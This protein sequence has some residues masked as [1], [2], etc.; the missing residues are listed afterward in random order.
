MFSK[1]VLSEPLNYDD[2][3]LSKGEI[4][5]TV[6]KIVL[7]PFRVGTGSCAFSPGC[8]PGLE[9]FNAF[10]VQPSFHATS[11]APGSLFVRRRC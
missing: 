2:Q 7:N 3:F 9:L 8:Y 10:G 1:R 11:T 5:E 4:N 6:D